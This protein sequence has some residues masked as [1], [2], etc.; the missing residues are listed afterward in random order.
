MTNTGMA[1]MYNI[2][3]VRDDEIVGY[4]GYN[5]PDEEVLQADKKAALALH[6]L[7]TAS[8]RAR[9]F[10][11]QAL[12]GALRNIEDREQIMLDL[13]TKSVTLSEDRTHLIVEVAKKILIR[14]VSGATGNA[15]E[16]Y[17]YEPQ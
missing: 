10:L 4:L 7:K 8:K 12:P 13:C 3:F 9:S 1:V 2:C 15:V 17:E 14:V 16:T 5:G 6:D 11:A